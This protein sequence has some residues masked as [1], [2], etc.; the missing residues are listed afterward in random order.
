[1][2]QWRRWRAI[3]FGLAWV[4]EMDDRSSKRVKKNERAHRNQKRGVV[5]VYLGAL[6]HNSQPTT[7][8]FP[9]LQ[10]ET[11]HLRAPAPSVVGSHQVVL[12]PKVGGRVTRGEAGAGDN[13]G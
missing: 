8:I 2:G 11:P 7:P 3:P 4:P 9:E 1:M 10:N 6:Y 12:A 5:C 13:V